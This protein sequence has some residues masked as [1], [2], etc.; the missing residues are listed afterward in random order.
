MLDVLKNAHFFKDRDFPFHVEEYLIGPKERIPSHSHEFIEFVY[1]AEGR[2]VHQYKGER[3][4][5]KKGDVFVIE[6]NIS[7]AYE[8][9]QEDQLLVYN[10]LFLPS[11][12]NNELKAL[13]R[14]NSF[15]DFFFVEPFL[16]NA[17][18][19]SAH[20]KLNGYE[21]AEI[22]KFIQNLLY[23]YNEK[24]L[25]Y[26]IMA[27]THM[28]ELFVFLSRCYDKHPPLKTF[29]YDEQVITYICRFIEKHYEKDLTLEQI[30]KMC[31]MSKTTFSIKFKSQTGVSLIEFRNAVRIKQS[32]FLLENTNQTIHSISGNVGFKDLSFF[33][34]LFKK[35][36]GKTPREYR[37]QKSARKFIEPLNY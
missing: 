30:S 5:I 7:H 37:S 8:V 13:S 33:N 10:I 1:V 25:G 14:V 4:Y 9:N 3:F 12:L 15:V 32:L 6:P 16:R 11:L 18:N 19:F 20:L 17:M 27:I 24:K 35:E 23:E 2:G 34:K 22:K 21:Q 26:R 29:E 31:G 36:I 28:I